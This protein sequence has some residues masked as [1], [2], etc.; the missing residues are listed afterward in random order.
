[1]GGGFFRSLKR[2]FSGRKKGSGRQ[3][4]QQQ[5]ICVQ[6]PSNMMDEYDSDEDDFNVDSEPKIGMCMPYVLCDNYNIML[7]M[8][9]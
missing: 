4:Q 6:G 3:Q 9:E 2:V 5:D 1:M 8:F 7:S